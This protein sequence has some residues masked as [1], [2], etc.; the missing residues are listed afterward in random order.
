MDPLRLVTFIS[1]PPPAMGPTT[2]RFDTEPSTVAP[3]TLTNPDPLLASSMN[4]TEDSVTTSTLP[5]PAETTNRGGARP[6][7]RPDRSG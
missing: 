1:G 6:E 5:D 7:G 3:M 2:F 4:G